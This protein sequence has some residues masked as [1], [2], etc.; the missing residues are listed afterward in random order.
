MSYHPQSREHEYPIRNDWR[1][2][3]GELIRIS[4][5]HHIWRDDL[6]EEQFHPYK[7]STTLR[8]EAGD[9]VVFLHAYGYSYSGTNWKRDAWN[10]KVLSPTLG[11]IWVSDEYTEHAVES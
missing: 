11:I 6:E 2:S 7:S 10:L 4:H 3:L 9:L 8:V 1:Y 5:S